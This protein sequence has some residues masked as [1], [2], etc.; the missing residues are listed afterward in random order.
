MDWRVVIAYLVGYVF[1][2]WVSYV[3]PVLPL[4]ITPWNPPPALSLFLLLRFGQRHWPWLFVAAFAADYLV[5]GLPARWPVHVEAAA[6]LTAAY[7]FAADR[8]RRREPGGLA[9][10]SPGALGGF[11]LVI[12]PVT[13][14]VA[15]AYVVLFATVGRVPVE[16]LSSS[17]VRH[18]VGDLIG[19]L[20]FA[21]VLLVVPWS[22]VRS[23]RPAPAVVAECAAQA[24][25]LALALWIVFGVPQV[26]EFKS[27]YLLFLPVLWMAVRWGLTG[28]TLGLAAAQLGLIVA[29][30]FGGYH[31]ATFVQLQV[32]TLTLAVTALLLG[33]V[34][35]QRGAVERALRR[36]QDA[37]NRSL[38]FA[39]AGEM[40]SALAHELNQPMTALSNYLRASQLM[41]RDPAHER[42]LLD[43]TMDKAVN[44]AQRA[45]AVMQR[46][47]DFFRR[48]QTTLEAVA[49]PALVADAVD[50]V[51]TRAEHAQVALQVE[52]PAD[53]VPV[54]ADRVQVSL[55][56]H[57]LLA[58]AIEAVAQA[59]GA[60]REVRIAL[61]QDAKAVRVVVEDTGAGIAPEV[62][63][64]MFEPF[65]TTKAEGMG[66]GLAISRTLVR[67]NGGDLTAE[68][69]AGGGARFV[70]SL[71]RPAAEEPA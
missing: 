19:I 56:I 7:A 43:A 36:K 52:A 25:S 13:A 17:V 2:D 70:L 30:Q 69:G 58:N 44:E 3:H 62:A 16:S 47:R 60:R 39:A 35:S 55:V 38:Q 12:V 4:G 49:V 1:L 51:R 22:R 41:L 66:L 21:P 71:P 61:E 54:R 45:G 28:A 20:V 32:L 50:A 6:L 27:F 57:N 24:A 59:G 42:A 65:T 68:P 53:A 10:D 34:V 23:W 11:L 26:D 15:T 29:I 64:T 63:A 9:L 31:A 18:W 8:L 48:G 46:L 5:R 40:S 14:V 37:L 33:A 67:A